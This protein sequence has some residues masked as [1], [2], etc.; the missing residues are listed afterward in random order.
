MTLDELSNLRSIRDLTIT[1]HAV[2]KSIAGPNNLTDV[3][4]KAQITDNKKLCQ[5]DALALAARFVPSSSE[6]VYRNSGVCNQ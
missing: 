2:L 5:N 1:D 3:G 4:S 6:L